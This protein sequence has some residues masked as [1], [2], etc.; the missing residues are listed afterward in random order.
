MKILFINTG[1]WGTGSFTAIKG[2]SKNL[3]R[4]G[5]DVKIFFPDAGLQ[6]EDLNEYYHQPDLY[7]IWQFPIGNA[8]IVLPTFPLMLT[9]PHP[10]N[11][12]PLYF[13]HLKSEALQFYLQSLRLELSTL[14]ESFKPDV[15]ECHHI[16]YASWILHTMNQSYLVTAHH[17]DQLGFRYDTRVRP[18]A[19]ASA[20][21]A[22][23]IFVISEFVKEEVM[24]LYNISESRIVLSKNGFDKEIFRARVIDKHQK[25]SKLDIS[26]NPEATF[27]SFA[28]KISLNK[29]IDI[30][31]KANKLLPST[32][33]IHFIVMGAGS[34]E[35]I[36][37]F[38]TPGSY[39]LKNIHFVGHQTPESVAE[40]HNIS[41][42]SIMPSRSEGFGIACLEAMGCGLPVVVSKSGGPEEFAVGKIIDKEAPE[43]LAAAIEQLVNLPVKE[44]KKLS[45]KSLEIANQYTW[46]NIVKIH[47]QV[48]DKIIS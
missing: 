1:P 30:L 4:L 46:E 35:P 31:L 15:I 37:K 33:N 18:Y 21:A 43:Q 16:W 34:I 17:S 26:V 19:I 22:K 28:G 32:L 20:Q 14:I 40:I 29:G 11:P 36:L 27:I 24:E 44:Y 48:Y 42:V 5:Y 38:M 41:K 13:N 23:K 9:D 2:L 3:L 25:L 10:R 47:T 45:Q 6:S 8:N 12:E 39:S 7:H